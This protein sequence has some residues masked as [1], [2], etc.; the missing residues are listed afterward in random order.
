MFCDHCRKAGGMDLDKDGLEAIKAE[1]AKCPGKLHCYCQHK[2]TRRQPDGT[3]A[4]V[5]PKR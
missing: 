4:Q 3:F 5:E 2:V 1:H